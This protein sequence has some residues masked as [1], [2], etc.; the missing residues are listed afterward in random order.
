M[1]ATTILAPE[2]TKQKKGF[3]HTFG[4]SGERVS[5]TG[6][7]GVNE[8]NSVQATRKRSYAHDPPL[9]LAQPVCIE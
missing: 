8:S 2:K 5:K 6:K 1:D 9:S 7:I 4:E 3:I